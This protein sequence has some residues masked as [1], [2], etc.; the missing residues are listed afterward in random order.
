MHLHL[1]SLLHQGLWGAERLLE[2]R[3][4]LLQVAL[5]LLGELTGHRIVDTLLGG[6][7]DT[8]VVLALHLLD[9]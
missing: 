1:A 6:D 9:V 4:E 8:F 7:V 3:D 5:H 2:G